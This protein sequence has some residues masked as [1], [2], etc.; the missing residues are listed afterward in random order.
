MFSSKSFVLYLLLPWAGYFGSR[1]YG[2]TNAKETQ[3]TATPAIKMSLTVQIKS[4]TATIGLREDIASGT[5]TANFETEA[6]YSMPNVST[7]QV[8][9]LEI[10]TSP[11]E[12]SKQPRKTKQSLTLQARTSLPTTKLTPHVHSLASYVA[13]SITVPSG[14]SGINF[15]LQPSSVVSFSRTMTNTFQSNSTAIL[16]ASES[17]ANDGCTTGENGE[18][19]CDTYVTRWVD[20]YLNVSIDITYAKRHRSSDSYFFI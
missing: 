7:A 2:L 15:S 5:V 6:I 4:S 3:V 1:H 14:P 9:I 12:F 16:H 13:S 17:S 8:T 18:K 10:P 11:S 20:F 19:S